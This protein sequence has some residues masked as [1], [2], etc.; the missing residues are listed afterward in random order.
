MNSDIIIGVDAGTTVIKAVAFDTSGNQ[1]GM[2]DRPNVYE[3]YADGRTEQDMIW[4]W[5]AVAETLGELTQIIPNL[6]Q[7]TAAISVTGQGDG[8]WLI[9]AKGEPISAALL[10]QDAR[11]ADIAKK[12]TNQTDYPD[13]FMINATGANPC[14]QSAQLAWL[15]RNQPEKLSKAATAMHCKDWLF[16]NLTGTRA[17]DPSE[18]TFTFGNFRTRKYSQAILDAFDIADLQHLLPPM[19]DGIKYAE[20]LSARAA[21]QTGLR[22]GTPVVMGYIDVACSSLGGGL[23]DPAGQIGCSILGSTGIHMRLA[24]NPNEVQLNKE[25]SGY[26]IPFPYENACIQM[27]S[28]MAAAIN[29]D[30]IVDIAKEVLALEG[31]K[32]TRNQLLEIA[33][34]HIME[35]E[36]GHLIYHPYISAAG[37]RGP[38]MESTARAGFIGIDTDTGYFSLMRAVYEGM[39]FAAR[40]CYSAMGPLP[41]EI[42]VTGGASRSRALRSILSDILGAQI[43][44][45]TRE[46]TG[47]A[48][49]A[50]IAAVQIGCYADLTDCVNDWVTPY[51]ESSAPLSSANVK[52]RSSYFETYQNAREVL[53][54]VWREL[55]ATT[56]GV[57]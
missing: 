11:A 57:Q 25:C 30:W 15:K 22:E 50:M 10:W 34:T 39:A 46:E 2:A 44:C 27:Q 41:S 20:P 4:T 55:A 29:I 17:T 19:I 42:M 21:C 5:Q 18:G 40:D 45:L 37:E 7:R 16:F 52:S 43:R 38:F 36:T 8:T 28:N 23:F 1:I 32:R 56:K 6:S 9:D 49:A 53:R 33:D 48:G 47:A 35:K 3:T 14:Q 13:L 24:L 54:P 26:T 31:I 12:I 51:L